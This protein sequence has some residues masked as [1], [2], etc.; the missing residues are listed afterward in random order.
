MVNL[1]PHVFRGATPHPSIIRFLREGL[2]K[3]VK[4]QFHVNAEEL[5]D[6][7]LTGA[8][9]THNYTDTSD[10]DLT[11]F[12]AYHLWPQYEED[13]DTL[14][15]LLIDMVV[16]HLDGTYLPG[17][18]HPLQV[19]VVAFGVGPHDL[20]KPG[21]RA[22]WSFADEDWFTKPISEPDEIPML[23]ARAQAM[24]DKME[25]LLQTNRK[26][27]LEFAEQI[28]RKQKTDQRA[29]LGD[30]SENT[31]VY[32]WMTSQGYFDRL[33]GMSLR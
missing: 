5:F 29:G 28:R 23:F 15:R 20:Y 17:T 16:K 11:V 19:F 24:A 12:P 25:L 4:R 33:R 26:T 32:K 22:A 18:E 14:R 7:Y 1:D 3:A 21:K 13:P 10:A 2:R 8:L 31:I 6:S 27:A 30:G 9:V